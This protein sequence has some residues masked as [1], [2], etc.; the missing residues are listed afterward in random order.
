M[1]NWLGR[2]L[3]SGDTMSQIDYH[4][5]R[6]QSVALADGQIAANYLMG[7]HDEVVTLW[8]NDAW[9]NGSGFVSGAWEYGQSVPDSSHNYEIGKL[10]LRSPHNSN[11][12]TFPGR[13]LTITG[14]VGG[15]AM[16]YTENRATLTGNNT[17]YLGATI[18]GDGRF[19]TL[20]I[21]TETNRGVLIGPSGGYP[22]PAAGTTLTIASTLNSPAAC[23]T[24]QTTPMFPNPVVGI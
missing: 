1:T 8:A 15:G 13:S 21:S 3:W 11:N 5:V 12:S 17:G 4:D 18:I 14:G 22:R 20:K 7:P 16:I 10:L 23:N 2:S 24:L 9:P 6:I 19:S